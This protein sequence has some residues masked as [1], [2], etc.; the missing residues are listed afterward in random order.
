MY[1]PSVNTKREKLGKVVIN[2]LSDKAMTM[3]EEF[4]WRGFLK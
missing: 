1:N 2:G 4:Y 3:E